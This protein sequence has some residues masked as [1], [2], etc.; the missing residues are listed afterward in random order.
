MQLW[1]DFGGGTAQT[2]T[3]EDVNHESQLL[4]IHCLKNVLCG[5]GPVG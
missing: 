2:K 3:L 4:H 5:L 1:E